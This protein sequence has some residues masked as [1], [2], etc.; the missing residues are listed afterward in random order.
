MLLAWADGLKAVDLNAQFSRNSHK[1]DKNWSYLWTSKPSKLK[2]VAKSKRWKK[3]SITQG[4]PGERKNIL[5]LRVKLPK[6]KKWKLPAVFVENIDQ[7]FYA[8]AGK[9]KIYDW[10]SLK[11]KYRDDFKGFRWHNIPL[12]RSILVN[13]STFKSIPLTPIS[14]SREHRR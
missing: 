12:K 4:V 14:E 3:F 2:K 6:S 13:I 10:G 8:Y 1:L 11:K 7:T 9:K 5:W